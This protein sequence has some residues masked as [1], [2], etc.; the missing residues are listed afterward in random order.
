MDQGVRLRAISKK[1]DN[2]Y[3]QQVFS[4]AILAQEFVIRAIWTF[5]ALVMAAASKKPSQL[6]TWDRIAQLPKIA[7]VKMAFF[8]AGISQRSLD[9]GKSPKRGMKRLEG[10][11]LPSQAALGFQ[12]IYEKSKTIPNEN[13]AN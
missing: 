2:K 12:L 10:S 7:E 13:K 8:S 1:S 3:F 6:S 5:L 11:K 9:R 4:V